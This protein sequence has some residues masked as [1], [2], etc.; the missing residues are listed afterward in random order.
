MVIIT[1]FFPLLLSVGFGAFSLFNLSLSHQERQWHCRQAALRFAQLLAQG[2]TELAEDSLLE[3]KSL[4][5]KKETS[6]SW[7]FLQE[8][9]LE[10]NWSFSVLGQIPIQGRCAYQQKEGLLL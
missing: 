7:Q 6:V 9:L 3:L 1:T 2:Q 8:E 5:E 10:I 4:L